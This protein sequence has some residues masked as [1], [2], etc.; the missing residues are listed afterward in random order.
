MFVVVT[1]VAVLCSL[2]ASLPSRV[3]LPLLSIVNMIAA[4]GFVI[5][6][7][8]ATAYF[9][10]IASILILLCLFSTDW[11]AAGPH[12][13]THVAWPPLIAACIFEFATIL[14]CFLFLRR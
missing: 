4:I 9:A 6:G 1:V 2:L 12:P 11:G 8:L 10:V 7:K 5:R 13:A 14:G 3:A